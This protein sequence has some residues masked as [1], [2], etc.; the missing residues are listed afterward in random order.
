M[1]GTADEEAHH[2]KAEAVDLMEQEEGEEE[3]GGAKEGTANL[4]STESFFN[5]GN[6]SC[7]LAIPEVSW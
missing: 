1:A 3:E 5:S 7:E 6:F 4:E 2:D